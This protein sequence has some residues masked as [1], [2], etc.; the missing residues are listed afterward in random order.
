MSRQLAVLQ[1]FAGGRLERQ[2][3]GRAYELVTP[4]VRMV[5]GRIPVADSVGRSERREA[6]V[7]P[8]AKGA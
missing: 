7:Q 2:W 8:I 4:T 1:E 6:M 5:A 3:L